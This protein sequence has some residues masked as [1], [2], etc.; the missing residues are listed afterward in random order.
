MINLKYFMLIL[1]LLSPSLSWSQGMTFGMG[2]AD[3]KIIKKQ[4]ADL[5][6]ARKQQEKANET[7]YENLD[8]KIKKHVENQRTSSEFRKEGKK[9][10]K[11]TKYIRMMEFHDHDGD[12]MVDHDVSKD[13]SELEKAFAPENVLK[14]KELKVY[15][16]MKAHEFK[17]KDGELIKHMQR[18]MDKAK[19]V[20][21]KEVGSK[22][23]DEI[24]VRDD[25]GNVISTFAEDSI[26]DIE[27]KIKE[28]S[29]DSLHFQ[30]LKRLEKYQDLKQ[31]KKE[32]RIKSS[33]EV[34]EGKDRAET[35]YQSGSDRSKNID[36][37]E[38]A[39]ARYKKDNPECLKA[40]FNCY[41]DNKGVIRKT[42]ST[43]TKKVASQIEDTQ[44]YDAQ[45]QVI[46]GDGGEG[47][48]KRLPGEQE[49]MTASQR[50]AIDQARKKYKNR[51]ALIR[52]LV[53][54]KRSQKYIGGKSVTVEEST[55]EKAT[56]A[57][58]QE[59]D[60]ASAFRDRSVAGEDG[61]IDLEKLK[62]HK[63][64]NKLKFLDY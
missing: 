25:A 8:K 51:K 27:G 55:G 37:F 36:R 14:G 19:K 26:R 39:L 32:E 11:N 41:V 10:A 34:K 18:K 24:M 64:Q 29:E 43:D 48:L 13:S 23:A 12:G 44:E 1:Y 6:R 57:K 21:A 7:Y 59:M 63:G 50:Q 46:M 33:F 28:H 22:Y 15:R 58:I 4:E 2:A 3:E 61:G 20:K 54:K 49:D 42:R 56:D 16:Y 35:T 31:K 52:Q 9:N 60:K 5:D 45:T 62:K 17:N 53:E 47:I 30:R 40:E 38:Q